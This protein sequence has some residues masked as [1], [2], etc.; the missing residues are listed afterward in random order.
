MAQPRRPMPVLDFDHNEYA[1]RV[2]VA[3]LPTYSEP[4]P[5]GVPLPDRHYGGGRRIVL[6]QG[7]VSPDGEYLSARTKANEWIVVWSLKDWEGR[8]VGVNFCD[9]EAEL[10]LPQLPC[11]QST[12]CACLFHPHVIVALTGSSLDAGSSKDKPAA[13]LRSGTSPVVV[14]P[15]TPPNTRPELVLMRPVPRDAQGH[16]VTPPR[17]LVVNV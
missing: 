11:S 16:S 2:S 15:M 8:P 9:I 12:A 1:A 17:V 10:P 14:A 4:Y 3:R 7:W 13:S 6:V 5:N